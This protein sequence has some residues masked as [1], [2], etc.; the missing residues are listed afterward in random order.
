MGIVI[1]GAAGH[2]GRQVAELVLEEADPADVILVTR[3][4]EAIADL[5]ERGAQVR[6]GDFDDP[7]SLPAALAGGTRM[8]LISTDAI[9]SRIAQHTAAIHAAR[10]AGVRHVVYTS[11]TN[12]AQDGPLGIVSTEHEGTERALRESGLTW[13]MLRNSV[14]S[15]FLVAPAQAALA[16]GAHV[17][18][19]GDGRVGYV[20]REDCGRAAAAVL[21][22]DGHEGVA[23]DITGPDAVDPRALA[24]AFS[25]AGGAPVAVSPVDDAAYV[26]ILVDAGTPA[27]MAGVLA[28]FGRAAR[29]GVLDVA[30]TA[31]RDLTGRDPLSVAAVLRDG[32]AGA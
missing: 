14:Y 29:E 26:Q 16:R 12:P 19:A 18:N 28:D 32:L 30:S 23:Y 10:R 15:D 2:L 11:V 6:H 1:T 4:P 21:L 5:A 25:E 20:A 17:T 3:R 24:A 9:G 27:E 31:V 13:T 22:T 8:L 7:A